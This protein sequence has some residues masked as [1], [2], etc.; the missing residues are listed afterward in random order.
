MKTLSLVVLSVILS[1]TASPLGDRAVFRRHRGAPLA[2]R[3]ILQSRTDAPA[4]CAALAPPPPS[5]TTTAPDL[6]STD[7]P[8]DPTAA[9]NST[10]TTDP[11]LASNTTVADP[12]ATD[13]STAT[14]NST[15]TRRFWARGF[16][17]S[18]FHG[19][20][21]S[22][23]SSSFSEET[24]VSVSFEETVSTFVETWEDLCLVSGG[25]IFTGDPCNS[26]AGDFGI[27][28]LSEHADACDQLDIADRMITFAKSRGIRNKDALIKHALSFRAHPR[29]AVEVLGVIPSSLYCLRAPINPELVGIYNEQ[30][31]GVNPGIFGSPSVPLVPFG[32][33]GTCPLG[34]TADMSSCGCTGSDGTTDNTAD[35]SADSTDDSTDSTDDSTDSTDDSADS[36]D[37]TDSSD[38]TATDSADASAATDATSTDSADAS[39]STDATSTDSS[40]AAP[41]PTDTATGPNFQPTDISGNV[42]DPAGRRK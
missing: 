41:P 35:E 19:G 3:H 28:A 15:A 5:A 38:A 13:N 37:S 27:D 18:G 4:A 32:S 7:I 40:A 22:F 25:D 9:D 23:D 39:V 12:T 30:I 20:F 6:S 2:R 16:H 42:N 14:T 17:G 36:T 24:T 1:V 31:E 26:L 33:S 34:M 10:D 21:S 11:S 29:N 8:V